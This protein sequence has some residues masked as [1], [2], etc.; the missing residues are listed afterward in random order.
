MLELR[1][2]KEIRYQTLLLLERCPFLSDG[3]VRVGLRIFG[4]HIRSNDEKAIISFASLGKELGRSAKTIQ[5]AVRELEL[6]GWLVLERG[7][8]IGHATVFSASEN[9]IV[10]ANELREKM[11]KYGTLQVIEGGQECPQRVTN[12][13]DRGGQ[14][15]PPLKRNNKNIKP[16]ARGEA[17]SQAK[18]N[19]I[20]PA[21]S[22]PKF[23][24][25]KL[26]QWHDWLKKHRLPELDTI[27]LCNT[28]NGA[29]K[30]RLPSNYPP[31]PDD[32]ERT[33]ALVNYFR[34][35]Q[36]HLLQKQNQATSLVS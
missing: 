30:Y 26:D 7:N 35:K 11:D 4:D 9:T 6:A 20:I 16:P 34:H 22:I 25:T 32:I 2:F 36:Q 28:P 18:V 31:S 17:P 12:V 24:T 27:A 15:R 19:P 21:I 14:N 29:N 8:G 10:V 13:S 5:R 3:A 1:P 33:T 23:Q